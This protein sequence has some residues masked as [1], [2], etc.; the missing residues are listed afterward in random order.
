M[1][2]SKYDSKLDPKQNANKATVTVPSSSNPDLNKSRDPAQAEKGNEAKPAVH[3]SADASSPKTNGAASGDKTN[4]ETMVSEGGHTAA[5]DTHRAVREP[6]A[7]NHAK[8]DSA[9]GSVDGASDGATS[10]LSAKP[11]S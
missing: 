4:S 5:N 7:A 11:A 9:K 3:A 1:N 10:K 2:Q 8:T 6:D